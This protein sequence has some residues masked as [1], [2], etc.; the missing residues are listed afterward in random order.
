LVFV[1][2]SDSSPLHGAASHGRLAL[3]RCFILNG[4]DLLATNI[5]GDTPFDRANVGRRFHIADYILTVAYKDQVVEREG[6][7]S[8]HAILEVAGYR[9]L[10]EEEESEEE[11]ENEEESVQQQQHI[12][13]VSLPIG[14]LTIDQFR[15]L[16]RSFDGVLMRQPDITG[17]LPFHIACQTATPV[18]ILKVLFQEFPGALQ[19]ADNSG[20]VPLHV[21]FQADVPSLAV[22]RFLVQRDPAA[23]RALDNEGALPLHRL[24]GSNPLC[25]TVEFLMGAYEGSISVRTHNGDLSFMVACQTRASLSVMLILLRMSAGLTL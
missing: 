8:I 11:Q 5:D 21:A 12:L 20:S 14:K 19:I 16:L 23:V 2:D 17:M 22:L 6:N 4:A 13:Q 10:V 1:C 25:N 3:S 15:V 24:C 9:Y 7:R 18:K